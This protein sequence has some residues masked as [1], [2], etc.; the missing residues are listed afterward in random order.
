MRVSRLVALRVLRS[1]FVSDRELENLIKQFTVLASLSHPNIV[2]AYD[3]AKAGDLVYSALEYVEGRSLAQVPAEGKPPDLGAHALLFI[4]ALSPADLTLEAKRLLQAFDALW[5]DWC[6]RC[7]MMDSEQF[8]DLTGKPV[9][10]VLREA[11]GYRVE[12]QIPYFQGIVGYMVEASLLWIR[13]SRFPIL[14]IAYDQRCPDVLSS[15]V[16]K[17]QGAE[18]S[19]IPDRPSARP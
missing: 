17:V 18:F 11:I 9:H 4:S 5:T 6:G 13:H 10:C 14:F 8:V 7:T 16:N 15:V 3:C 2:R 19:N 1:E 12:Y